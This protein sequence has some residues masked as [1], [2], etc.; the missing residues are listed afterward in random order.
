MNLKLDLFSWEDRVNVLSLFPPITV[1][2]S[3]CLKKGE[4]K[5][6]WLRTTLELKKGLGTGQPSRQKLRQ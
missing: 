5:A 2:K 3:I 6:D 4:K 1:T